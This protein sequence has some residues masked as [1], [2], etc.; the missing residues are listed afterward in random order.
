MIRTN[1]FPT[2]SLFLL[3]LICASNLSA[4]DKL[5]VKNPWV[6]EAP[7]NASVMAA[8]F[9]LH[10]HAAKGKTLVNASSPEFK[11][12]E[13]HRTEEHDGMAKM[14]AVHNLK[15]DGKSSIDFKPG[16]LH[17]ML[18]NPKKSLKAGDSISL[19]LHFTDESS[20]KINVPVKKAG[21]KMKHDMHH[22]MN[23][24]MDH[25]MDHDMNH[26]MHEDMRDSHSH[27]HKH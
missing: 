7:P 3:L 6:R 2:I 13:L 5:E 11:R 4:A 22:N 27:D 21:A 24:D 8:Y 18:I 1:R 26:D 12:V 19:T 23:H 25:K 20:L 9:S 10:N 16:G 15:L 17:I 14:I